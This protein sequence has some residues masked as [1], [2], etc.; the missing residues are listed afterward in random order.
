MDKNLK[1]K[2]KTAQLQMPV[3]DNI[4]KAEIYL[5]EKISEAA[6]Q[7]ADLVMLPEMFC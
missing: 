4:N 6:E 5:N 3:I 2:I 1:R 7:G